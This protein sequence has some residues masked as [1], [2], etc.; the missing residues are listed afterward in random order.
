MAQSNRLP[1]S[2]KL[3]NRGILSLYDAYVLGFSNT[4]AWRCP[5]KYLL[6][7]YHAHVG[8]RHLDIGPGTG[9]FLDRCK[10]PEQNPQIDL[11]DINEAP[12][13]NTSERIRRYHPRTHVGDIYNPPASIQGPYQSIGINY[14]LHCLPG[15]LTEKGDPIL[16]QWVKTLSC[17]Q[18]CLFGSTILGQSVRHNLLGRSLMQ[19]YNDR[20]IFDNQNDELADLEQLMNRHF[21]RHTLEVKGCVALFAGFV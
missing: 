19:F 3:Y 7:H 2:A 11:L 17:N 14:V 13:K 21:A 9:F 18:G 20:K 10:F 5:T 1:D 6:A 4:F 15:T 12:L 16:E 8:S